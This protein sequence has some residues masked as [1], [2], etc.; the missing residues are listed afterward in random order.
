[1]GIKRLCA[2]VIGLTLTLGLLAGPAQALEVA[3][4]KPLIQLAILLDTS[5]S[6]DGLINQARTQLWKV[7]NELLASR[8][9]GQRPEL[10]VAV[11]EYGNQ[12]LSAQSGYIRLVTPLTSDLDR[13]SEA[14]FALTTN[15]GDEYCG[16][17]ISVATEQLAWSPSP[18]DLKLVYIAGNEPFTQGGV[19]FRGAVK[20]AINRGIAVNTIHC[21]T[22]EEGVSSGWKE[23]AMLAD[24]AYMAIDQNR[25]VPQ[26]AAPQ[27]TEITRLGQ[28]LNQTYVA[29][30]A[31]GGEAKARQKMEDANASQAAPAAAAERAVFKSSAGYRSGGWDLV[32]AEKEGAVKVEDLAE[33][34]LPSEMRG[35]KPA[36][37]KAYLAGQEKKRA[38]LQGRIQKLAEERKQFIAQKERE[39]AKGGADTLDGAMLKSVRE[40]AQKKAFKFE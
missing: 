24:G 31:A 35:M 21:G 25:A 36:E 18:G 38:E 14:L 33:E 20:A 3:G 29:Y 17:V 2:R 12:G 7:V 1:M 15:G 16:Q 37:R 13:V 34:Q 5:S 6:M 19:D 8:K 30:G 26:I 40:Q 39:A 9:A 22:Y 10:Q 23:G 11:F 28:E 4:G 32:D 27:D